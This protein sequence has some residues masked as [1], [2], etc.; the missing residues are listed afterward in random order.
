V[1]LNIDL[2]RQG[3]SYLRSHPS[4]LWQA[5][6]NAARF[7]LSLPVDVLRWVIDRRPPGKGPTRIELFEADPALGLSLAVDLYGTELAIAAKI[8]VESLENADSQ[9]RLTLR[10]RDLEVKA[11]PASPAAMMVQSL[12]L[13]RPGS[14]MTM[15]PARHAALVDATDDRFVLDLLK[16]PALGNNLR[17]RRVLAALSFVRVTHVRADGDLIAIGVDVSPLGI[18]AAIGRARHATTDGAH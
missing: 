9:L 12:D 1:L 13:S 14:L 17:L 15:M 3:L 11:P 5:A 2:A 6:L 16:I 18:P 8:T 4:M 10:I 7:E